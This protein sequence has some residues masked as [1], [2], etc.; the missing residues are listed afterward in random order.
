LSAGKEKE[1]RQAARGLTSKNEMEKENKARV[2][3]LVEKIANHV[4]LPWYCPTE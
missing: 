2:G 4:P 3:A 1:T